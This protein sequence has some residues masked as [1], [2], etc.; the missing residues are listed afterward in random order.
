VAVAE[1]LN[2]EDA[3]MT[4]AVTVVFV[5]LAI[6]TNTHAQSALTV[7]HPLEFTRTELFRSLEWPEALLDAEA[8]EELEEGFMGSLTDGRIGLR[9]LLALA[10]DKLNDAE[11]S[12][13]SKPPAFAL[14][15]R[16]EGRTFVAVTRPGTNAGTGDR[17]VLQ[18][19]LVSDVLK[20]RQFS[21]T[22]YKDQAFDENTFEFLGV[23][24]RLLARPPIDLF[25]WRLRVQVFGSYHPEY[26]GTGYLTISGGHAPPPAVFADPMR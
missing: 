23:G 1:S 11:E 17:V 24:A 9:P 4:R 26:G 12:G 3:A 16:A 8:A 21:L 2:E 20:G 7:D 15:T 25:G 13:N 10:P 19:L 22:V 14:I 5:V 18:R 6:T